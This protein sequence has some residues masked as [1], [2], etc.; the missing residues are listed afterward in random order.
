[1]F[2]ARFWFFFFEF[3]EFGVAHCGRREIEVVH[4][5][6][7]VRCFDL[8]PHLPYLP[9]LPYLLL[10]PRRAFDGQD[11][12]VLERNGTSYSDVYSDVASGIFGETTAAKDVAAIVTLTTTW[13][14]NSVCGL[15]VPPLQVR[16]EERSEGPT[17]RVCCV[18]CAVVCSVAVRCILIQV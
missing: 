6:R 10:P 2:W 4:N 5:R 15:L 3:F 13:Q 18:L 8:L 7:W 1:M 14:E 17:L 16:E 9:Y 12:C 11:S